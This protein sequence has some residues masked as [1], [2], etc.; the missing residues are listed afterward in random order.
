[1]EFEIE[2]EA[3]DAYQAH[4]HGVNLCAEFY[5]WVAI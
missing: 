3:E 1:M 5:N 4:Y 2:Y